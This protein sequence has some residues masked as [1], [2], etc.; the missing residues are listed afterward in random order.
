MSHVARLGWSGSPERPEDFGGAIEYTRRL[1]I[2]QLTGES[3]L[4]VSHSIA[5]TQALEQGK[6]SLAVCWSRVLSQRALKPALPKQSSKMNHSKTSCAITEV[7][8]G[9]G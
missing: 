3:A 2:A 5:R 7:T 1:D 4:M 8:V 9:G 6:V